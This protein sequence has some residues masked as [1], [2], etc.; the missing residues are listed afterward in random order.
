[1]LM[2]DLRCAPAAKRKRD[3]EEPDPYFL[4]PIKFVRISSESG[5]CS[6]QVDV[7]VNRFP[8]IVE[9]Q[10]LSLSEADFARANAVLR[11]LTMQRELRHK[12]NSKD[13]GSSGSPNVFSET[14][15]ESF[16]ETGM[17]CSGT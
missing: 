1:M 11:E 7:L 14:S 13:S 12:Y 8:R 3:L 10:E 9:G 5:G 2:D 17:D 4:L 16:M 6:D 15:H